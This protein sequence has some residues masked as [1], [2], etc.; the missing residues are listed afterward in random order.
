MPWTVKKSGDKWAIVRADTGK[1][2][3]HSTSK[4][5][6]LASV[7]ARYAS[8]TYQKEHKKSGDYK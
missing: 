1:V 6:A 3:G 8:K 4:E 5:K 2:V 7:R